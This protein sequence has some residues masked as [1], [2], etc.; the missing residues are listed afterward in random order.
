MNFKLIGSN[1]IDDVKTTFF[2]NRG[3]QDVKGY[4]NLDESCVNDPHNLDNIDEAVQTFVNGLDKEIA[5]VVDCDCDGVM[6]AAMLYNYIKYANPDAKITYLLHEGKQH[7]LSNDIK[8]PDKTGL[9]LLPDSGTN[10][11]KQCKRLHDKGIDIIVLD[12]HIQ[13]VENPYAIVVNNQCSECYTNKELCGAGIVYQF[14]RLV[15][16]ELWLD[17]ADTLLDLCAIANIADVM[18]MRSF[19]TKYLV[20]RGLSQI[21][22]SGLEAFINGQGYQIK[23]NPTIH[24]IEWFV[25]PLINAVC[26]VGTQEDKDIVF[27]SFIGNESEE[28]S[29]KK[30]D[31][32]TGKFV[33]IQENIYDHAFRVAKNCKSRQDSVVKKLMPQ[34]EQWIDTHEAANNAVIFGRLPSDI[35][36]VYT[37]LVA[38]KI[39]NE[40]RKPTLILRKEGNNWKGSGRNFDNCPLENF[41]ELLDKSKQFKYAAGHNGAFGVM[42][43]GNNVESAITYCND[44]CKDIDFDSV[45]VDFSLDYEDLDIRFIIDV[46][47]LKEYFGTGLKEPIVHISNVALKRNQG[48]VIGKQSTTWKFTDDNDIVFLKFLNPEDDP[49]LKFLNDEDEHAED[50]IIIQDMICKVSFSEYNKILSAQVQVL[51]YEVWGTAFNVQ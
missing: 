35:D 46:D 47:K 32:D 51:N 41:K 30:K 1:N 17:Y 5:I 4:C 12:H 42:I 14:L 29:A 28:Y 45:K 6:S 9:L 21:V 33:T 2:N 26:R 19:E 13:E 50:A 34:V 11:A 25:S 16:E 38:I 48:V 39:A 36:N 23:G 20:E 10:D 37:G 24:D 8:V 22:N 49:V 44:Q 27:K 15:D 40:Y 43:D 18:D 31:P 7:G 3:I